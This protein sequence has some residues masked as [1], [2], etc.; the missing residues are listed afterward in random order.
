M[1][2]VVVVVAVL[3]LILISRHFSQILQIK[4]VHSYN[5][6][7]KDIKFDNFLMGINKHGN[8]VNIINFSL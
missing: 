5:F 1:V 6:I 8:Q 3:A 4:Y 2:V 7:H